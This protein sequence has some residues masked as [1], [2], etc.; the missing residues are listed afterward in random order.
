MTKYVSIIPHNVLTVLSESI[1]NGIDYDVDRN[2]MDNVDDQIG[3][4]VLAIQTSIRNV[5]NS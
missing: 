1:S 2:M 5:I 4:I 3:T